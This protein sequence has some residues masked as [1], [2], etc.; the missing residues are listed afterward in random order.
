MPTGQRL[1]S[2]QSFFSPAVRPW[3]YPTK[4]CSSLTAKQQ[5]QKQSIR[6]LTQLRPHTRIR[7]LAAAA[8]VLAASFCLPLPSDV[9]VLL[10]VAAA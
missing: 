1:G 2:F 8:A 9:S 7:I 3:F 5:Q 4:Q 6:F 10:P